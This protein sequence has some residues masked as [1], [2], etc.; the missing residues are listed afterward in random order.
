M[1]SASHANP[2]PETS[3]FAE[4]LVLTGPTG[5]GKTA[6]ALT[7]AERLDAEIVA[8]D[9]MTLYRG[10]DIGTAKPTPA[11]RARIPHHLIDVLDPWESANVAWWL[12]Q[13]ERATAAI[14]ARGK[15]VL[16]VGGTPF[17]LKALQ[18]GLFPAPPSDAGL[19]TQLE[20]EART[21]GANA[22]HARLAQVDPPSAARLHPNDIRRV[23]RALEVHTLTGQPLSAFQT[24]WGTESF[25]GTPGSAM[26]RLHY[27]VVIL[28][29][30]RE[31]LY[32]RIDARVEGMLAVG[33]LNEAQ[34]LLSLPQP[35][36]REASQALGY[37]ELWAYLQEP[38]SSWAEMVQRIQQRT[39]QYAKRQL[40][41]FRQ[42]QGSHFAPA[43]SPDPAGEILY[44]WRNC[45][46]K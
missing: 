20:D 36:S 1:T 42:I 4:V 24:S 37:A 23:V 11:E 32:A 39:R 5:S 22:L 16:F 28:D 12:E 13:A 38:E 35:L 31:L 2:V 33:W 34:R 41:W 25:Q 40:T 26:N 17:Y 29:W 8:M 6:L 30:P 18:C 3:P 46:Q 15:R 19:R 7:L 21:Q 14:Q 45:R 27:P 44:T 10:M 9:S 43:H